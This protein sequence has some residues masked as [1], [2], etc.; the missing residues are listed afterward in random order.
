LGCGASRSSSFQNTEDDGCAAHVVK[1]PGSGGNV[2]AHAR[3]GAQEIPEFVVT[4]AIPSCRCDALEAE[5][6][7]TSALDA[8]MVLLKTI[9]EIAV[10]PMPHAAAEL[11]PNGPGIGVVA[12]C[13][14]PVG[15]HV[16][17]GLC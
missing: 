8:T 7:P 12:V 6:R 10:G 2:L 16:G 1:A 17:D 15:D 4:V 3:P 13:R 11:C 14:D 5:H 9:V